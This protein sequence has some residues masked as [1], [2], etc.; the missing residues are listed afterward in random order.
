MLFGPLSELYGRKWP[1][2][3]GFLVFAIFNIPVAVAENLQTIMICR[4][5]VGFGGA[6]PLAIVGGGLAD[7]F[8][9]VTRGAAVLIFAGA[10]FMGSIAGPIVGGFVTQSYLGWRWTQWL[11]LIP[12]LVLLLVGV[13]FVPETYSPVL[14]TRRAR[15]LRLDTGNWALHSRNEAQRADIGDIA[16]TYLIR[17]IAMLVREPILLLV[18]IYMSLIYGILYLFFEAFPVSFNEEREWNLGV[19]A[20]PFLSIAIGIILGSIVILFHIR[21]RYASIVQSHGSVPPEERL[22]PMMLGSILLPAG[23]FWWAWTSNPNIIWVPQ[24]IAGVPIGMGLV[25]IFLQGLN[26]II[27]VYTKNANSAVAANVFLRSWVGAGFTMFATGMF[28]NLGV[29]WAT[30]LLAFLC[31]AL[32]PVPFLFWIYGAAIRRR[33]KF[34]PT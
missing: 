19:G 30:S 2:L 31:T 5:F 29:P 8:D 20:L 18:T 12:A 26:Y 34:V 24:V 6:A 7:I 15:N 14:L 33:S 11:T 22:L 10:T 16:R 23:L 21:L 13:F 28:H 32:V 25:M 3:S 1:L 17:P 9:P 4:F 27:D